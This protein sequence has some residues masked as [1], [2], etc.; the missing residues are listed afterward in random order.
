MTWKVFFLHL[1]GLTCRL[2]AKPR[3][4]YHGVKARRNQNHTPTIICNN[5]TA[6]F[7]LHDLSLQFR[8]PT[9]NTLFYSFEDFMLFVNN[10][11]EFQKAPLREVP[12]SYPYPVGL[13][14][15]NAG[16]VKIGFVHYSTFEEAATI[17]KKR[18]ARVDDSNLY[19]IFEGKSVT[20]AQVEAFALL[21]YRKAI[22]S[23]ENEEFEKKHS[24]YHGFKFYRKWH[25]G[26][27][28]DYKH[29]LS[30]RRNLD[31]FDYIAFLN[32]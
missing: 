20:A 5:C 21:P 17:W 26:L 3:A 7:L 13:L 22:L 31:D 14:Q 2:M 11:H 19:V 10:L 32:E 27:I 6:G 18:F 23:G 16:G 1:H 30:L 15:T 4:W 29:W 28:G 24:F 9:I 25:P 12:S 8:T